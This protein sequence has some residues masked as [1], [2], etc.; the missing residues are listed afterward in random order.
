MAST[1]DERTMPV[2]REQVAIA[3]E[4]IDKSEAGGDF[5]DVVE[6]YFEKWSEMMIVILCFYF[7]KKYQCTF[8]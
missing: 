8:F 7:S 4:H 2:E 3:D 5:G 1:G 6:I